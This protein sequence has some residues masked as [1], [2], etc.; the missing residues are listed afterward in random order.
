MQKSKSILDIY[1]QY[2][3]TIGIEVHVQ[4]KTKSKIFCGCQNVF[5]APPNSNICSVCTGMLGSLPVLNM[6]VVNY[7]ITAGL[8]TNCS[9]AKISEF[10][11][12]HYMYPDLPKNY[13]ISQDNKPICTDGYLEVRNNSGFK[14]IGITRI[15]LE[16][17][18]G[19]S[20]HGDNEKEQFSFI[21]LNRA[22]TPLAEIVSQPDITSAD[23]AVA[24]LEQLRSIVQY[25]GISTANMEEGSF[26][27]D[28]NVSVKKKDA[29]K[30]GTRVELKN[31]NS[32]RFIHDAIEYE[33]ERQI[34]L[35]EEG[36]R[37][38]QETRLWDNDKG[39]SFFM[40]SKED[41]QDYRYLADPDLPLVLIDEDWIKR[42]ADSMPELPNARYQRLQSDYA[43][44]PYEAEIISSDRKLADYFEKVVKKSSAPKKA[45]NWIL[46]DILGLMKEK[47]LEL[48]ELLIT[49]EMLAEL[50][51]ELEK[52]VINS[53]IAQEI[54]EEMAATGRYP[55]IIIQEKGLELVGSEEELLKIVD[56][57]I[58]LYPT[59][60][61]QYRS[62]NERIL[63][64]LVGQAM[65]ET[66]GKA[67]P[68]LLTELLKKELM[69]EHPH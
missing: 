2:Q 66:Q 63:G 17:D 61:G 55:S 13:Q 3:A 14:R 59:Q 4:L 25:I 34:E 27:A 62:G 38:T 20:F 10:A 44:S 33:L 26:R 30:L 24:Y 6:Q 48:D 47:K 68:V 50:I 52:G 15:H 43:L 19:K 22:G 67:D 49:A 54:F 1:P 53:K 8:A 45:A 58:G 37:V 32:F 31:I 29:E 41:A 42:I 5:G 39:K 16:E 57:I 51:V 11:R 65:K 35:L 9:I 46:R 28:V 18:A 40:R 21:D 64:F 7:A 60:V 56:K 69:P 36:K 12:K 23:E